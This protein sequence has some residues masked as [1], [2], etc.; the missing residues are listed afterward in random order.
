V[1][2][3]LT[4]VKPEQLAVG[5]TSVAA[6]A[7]AGDDVVEL[8]GRGLEGRLGVEALGLEGGEGVE[9][10]VALVEGLVNVGCDDIVGLRERV[11]G[12]LGPSR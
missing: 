8:A 12:H 1:T 11:M 5:P 6:A 2:C 9:G 4:A 10:V 3:D 7:A